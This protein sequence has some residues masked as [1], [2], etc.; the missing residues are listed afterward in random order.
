MHSVI[1]VYNTVH[2]VILVY[3]TVHSVMHQYNTVRSFIHQYNAVHS[4]MH[5]YCNNTVHS[6]IHQYNTSIYTEQLVYILN[7]FYELLLTILLTRWIYIQ[8]ILGRSFTSCMHLRTLVVASVHLRI[9][10]AGLL[11]S[12]FVHFLSIGRICQLE[13]PP[14][15]LPEQSK[16][17]CHTL[18]PVSE[19][20]KYPKPSI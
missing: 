6:F 1:L 7:N 9:P 4:V 19:S 3:N 8:G 18:I 13:P 2:S 14:S 10:Q 17:I 12:S 20:V 5:Q 15:N 16:Q 11:H